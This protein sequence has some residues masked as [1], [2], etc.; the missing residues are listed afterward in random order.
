MR[1]V[2][3][4]NDQ[5]WHYIY[6]HLYPIIPK[7]QDDP[8]IQNNQSLTQNNKQQLAVNRIKAWNARGKIPHSI[9][10]TASFVE[11][12]LTDKQ[13]ILNEHSLRLLYSA[14]FIRF[15]NGFIDP[16]QKGVYAQSMTLVAES[17]QLPPWFIEIRHQATHDVLPTLPLL[18]KATE[19]AL[20]WLYEFYWK[21]NALSH[22]ISESALSA[23]DSNDS[24]RN[25]EISNNFKSDVNEKKSLTDSW[26]LA[27][28]FDTS[29]P[30]GWAN[31]LQLLDYDNY[32][33][34][35]QHVLCIPSGVVIDSEP[36][37]KSTVKLL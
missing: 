26:I 11:I 28:D 21:P 1:R 5:E 19:Q 31:S 8:I 24:Y 35:N 20:D 15:V 3:W 37:K 6:T 12:Q 23:N 33:F 34:V 18:R 10:C 2:P 13:M 7:S 4:R 22:S 29:K 14:A 17:L 27:H 25:D 36:K 30:I 32:E 16:Q 9:E